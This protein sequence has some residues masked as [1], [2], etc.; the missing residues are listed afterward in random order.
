MVLI[1]RE[2]MKKR[3]A[4]T[5]GA[6]AMAAWAA[7]AE[8]PSRYAELDGARVHYE[9]Y[10]AGKEAVL[11]IHGWTCD[12]TFW[13]A[14]APVYEKRRALLIDLPGHG[15]SDKPEIAYTQD[16]FARS[17]DAVMRDAG[18]ERAVLVGHSMGTPVAL[19]FLR[20]FPAKVA[21]VVIVDG[22]IPQPPKDD[23][24]RQKRAAQAA[25]MR[26][27]YR[28]PDYKTAMDGMFK[29]MFT[30]QTP[31]ALREEIRT[32][33]LAAPQHV[34]ASA[35]EGM[36]ALDPPANTHFD[37]PAMAIMVK[38]ASQSSYEDYLRTLFPKLRAYQAWEGAGHFLM[39]EQPEKFNAALVEF[40]DRN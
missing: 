25:E 30:D 6:F 2:S 24:D 12:L 15:A 40:L 13:R 34:L 11:F 32:K 35:M 18:V 37:V 39:M 22:F 9:S 1:R 19:T 28:S 20:R 26:K 29:F 33:M 17:V 36:L 27:M 3:I 21:G 23:A 16:L 5:C 31:A 38:R 7:A 10:G 4:L 14:Q 8:A